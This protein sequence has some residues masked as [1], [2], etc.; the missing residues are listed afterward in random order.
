MAKNTFHIEF[1]DLRKFDQSLKYM[2]QQL[3]G[4]VK[5]A[6]T[7]YGSLV[8][9]GAKRLAPHKTGDLEAS[10]NF[11]E[12]V[13]GFGSVSVTGGTNMAYAMRAHEQ[14]GRGPGTLA[15]PIWRGYQPG[16]KYL[17][18]AIIATQIDYERLLREALTKIVGGAE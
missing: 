3:K 4:H 7:E 11:D 2:D 8:E 10:I 18:N 16:R 17:E 14:P 15:K 5:E 12:A 1:T 9:E 13:A 6:L